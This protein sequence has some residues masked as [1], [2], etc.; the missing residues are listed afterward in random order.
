VPVEDQIQ[1]VYDAGF[2]HMDM[3]FWDW[4]LDPASPFRKDNW[5]DWVEGIAKK[6]QAL[7]VK[8]TQAHA[9]VFNFYTGDAERYEMYLRCL[10]GAAMLGVPWIT[11]HPSGHPDF[12]PETEKKNIKDNIEYY[13]PLVEVAEKYRVGIALENMSSR[14]C[15]AEHLNQ[16]VDALD[17]PFVGICWDTGHAHIAKQPQAESI[18]LMGNRLH[19]LHIQDNDGIS[20]HH[21]P[22]H[23]GTIEWDPL[24]AALREINYPGDF[25]FEAHMIVRRVPEGCKADALRLLKQI[26][27][28]L[29]GNGY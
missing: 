20:D 27:E 23:F 24:M 28:E 15:K 17:S 13:K 10:E 26:G 8:F 16:M 6:A 14:L 21:M 1:R 22:P 19:A 5:R 7:N 25:T 18:R 29:V 3:N 9:D 11:F 12:S 2:R 4:A